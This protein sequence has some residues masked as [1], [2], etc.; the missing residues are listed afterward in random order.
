VRACFLGNITFGREIEASAHACDSG[1]AQ[2]GVRTCS[3][4]SDVKFAGAQQRQEE[5]ALAA[6]DT[7]PAAFCTVIPLESV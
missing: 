6:S 7:K 5:S 1:D 3:R 4:G 2:H